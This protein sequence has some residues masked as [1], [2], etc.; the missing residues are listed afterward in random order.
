MVTKKNLRDFT[1]AEMTGLMESMGEKTYRAEQVFRWVFARGAQDIDAM[2]D[3][4]LAMRERLKDGFCIK[5]L[6]VADVLRSVDGT[7]KFLSSLDDGCRIESVII[8]ESGRNTLCVSSQAGCAL[9]CVFCMTARGGLERNLTLAELTGQVFAA[10]DLVRS[11][12]GAIVAGHGGITNL[13]LMGMGEPLANYDNVLRF[14]K[15]LTD[16]RGLGFSHNKVTLSTAGLVPGI[17]KLARDSNVNLAV[18]LNATNDEVRS[19]LMP[20]NRKYPI[21]E[22]MSVLKRFPTPKKKH[23]TIEYVLIRGINDSDDD[24]RRLVSLLRGVD[25]KVN[26]IPFNP[27]PGS[28]FNRPTDERVNRFHEIVMDSGLTVLTRSSKGSD[29]Q[30]ACGQLRG[31]MPGHT[32]S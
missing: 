28:R 8:P 18:S 24:A 9:G 21:A 20:I 15:V 32:H 29:I 4:S 22:L 30:A 3:V 11:E 26:L 27:F 12:Q 10:M 1:Y 16:P 6:E 2:T 25:C 14:L 31:I 7:V 13:V 5:G 17:K 19:R 23:I